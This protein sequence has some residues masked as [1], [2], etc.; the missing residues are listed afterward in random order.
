MHITWYTGWVWLALSLNLKG[1]GSDN[2]L[3][4]LINFMGSFSVPGALR[5][6]HY[7]VSFVWG[8]VSQL[9]KWYAQLLTALL[10]G[11]VERGHTVL[12][13]RQQSY[14]QDVCNSVRCL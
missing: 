1:L 13:G 11:D 9:E 6:S 8:T 14:Y 4:V 2:R 12:Q 3:F 10:A 5:L 7:L